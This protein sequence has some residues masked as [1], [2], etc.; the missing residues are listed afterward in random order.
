M[1]RNEGISLKSNWHLQVCMHPEYPRGQRNISEPQQRFEV[2]R[3]FLV[4]ESFD[5]VSILLL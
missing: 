5:S 3:I 2:S 4:I 1:Q